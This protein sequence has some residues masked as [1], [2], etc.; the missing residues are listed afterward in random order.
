MIPRTIERDGKAICF[1]D[2]TL[3]PERLEVVACTD[4]ERLAVAIRRLEVRGAPALGIA[5]AYGV[6]LAAMTSTETAYGPFTAEVAKAAAYLRATRPTAVNLGWGID[7]TMAALRAAGT[8]DEAVEAAVREAD[9]IAHEDEESCRALGKNGAAL[10]PDGARVLTHCNAGALAC[11]TW[12]TALGVVRSALESGKKVS[13]TACETR[14]LLQGARLTAFELHEDGI[15]VRVITDSTAAFLMQRGEID[16]VVV[17]AD[18]ITQDA[19]F[20]KIGTYMHAVCARHHGIPFYVAAPVST[21]DT[22]R[23]AADVTIEERN[24]DEI[25]I[26]NGRRTVPAGVP[27]TNFAFDRTPLDLVSAIMTE[28]GVLHPPYDRMPD[29]GNI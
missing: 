21:F 6:A 13:V 4:V 10:I 2:Q 14:P 9:L 18:R 19:V 27:C 11:S 28:R 23:R 8:V 16:C 5:G 29:T 20:N 26:F 22:G 15:P 3:L 7:R 1:I 12:G 17:G 25:A 24:G